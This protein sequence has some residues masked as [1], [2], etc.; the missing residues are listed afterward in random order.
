MTVQMIKDRM[1]RKFLFVITVLLLS[2]S[3]CRSQEMASQAKIVINETDSPSMTEE[4]T[5]PIPETDTISP[6]ITPE[7]QVEVD[8]P[9]EGQIVFYSERDGNAE[10]YTMSPDGSDQQRLTSNPYEDVSP[11]WSSDGSKIVFISDR[12]DPNP[13]ECFPD[14][15]Y[16]LYSIDADGS[17]EVRLIETELSVHHPDWHPDGS[18]LSFDVEF[19]LE[20]N[21]YVLDLNSG[22]VQLLIEDGFW[23][24][25]SPDGTQVAYSTNRDGNIDIYVADADGNNPR[26]LTDNPRK[27][28]F[29]AWSP[30]GEKI[31]FMAGQGGTRQLYVMDADGS[32]QRQ[33]T[34]QGAVSED[35]AWSPDGDWIVFQS[36]RDGNYEIYTLNLEQELQGGDEISVQRLTNTV[37][38]D[39]WASWRP[40]ASSGSNAIVFEKSPQ[41]FPSVPTWKIGLDDFDADGDLDAVFANG[42]RNLSQIWLNDG[43]GIFID[44]GQELGRYGHGVDTGDVDGDG[45]PDIIISTHTDLPTRVYLYEGKAV[46]QEMEGAFDANI[47]FSVDLFDLDKDGDLDAV[48]EDIQSVNIYLNDGLGKFTKSDLT[49]PLTTAW[50]DLDSDGDID[51]LIKEEGIGYSVQLNDGQGNFTRY[52]ACEEPEA[53]NIGAMALN[54][55][56]G[57]G[58]LDAIIT[59]GHH[60][61]NSYP[62]QI[63]LN[64]GTGQFTD[65]GQR[66]NAVRNAGVSLGDLDG[67]GDPDLVLADFEEPCQ[68]WLNDGNGVFTDSGFRF[69]GDQFYRH[70]HLADL[71]GDSDLDIFLATFGTGEGPNEIWFNQQQ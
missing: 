70:I 35:P 9:A 8:R 61:T 43:R 12:D 56:D 21:I 32:N 16:Q 58:D 28:L 50:G 18:K 15:R 41:V 64:G 44:T 36:N 13:G 57:D 5:F 19:G 20:G 46:F 23:A 40:G 14:C 11:V 69:G 37:R 54:D 2:I 42:Q 25:W 67:D 31:A 10:I 34:E 45:D 52:W 53:M 48:G 33:V 49:F 66:L 7:V 51:V 47:G 4:A 6:T 68:I 24:D 62:V 59:N 63:Y 65:S 27:D 60:R 55:V 39:Y 30:D 17:N 29:P 71:D 22:E 38:G 26:R 1:M 3:A